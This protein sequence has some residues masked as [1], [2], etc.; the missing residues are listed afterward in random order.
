M[1][2]ENVFK[3]PYLSPLLPLVGAVSYSHSNSSS[4]FPRPGS[5]IGMTIAGASELQ[6]FQF[7]L[8]PD[9]EPANMLACMEA[10]YKVLFASAET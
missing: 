4:S 6:N 7:L 9:L 10:G 2:A 1:Y 5:A 3:R 8:L